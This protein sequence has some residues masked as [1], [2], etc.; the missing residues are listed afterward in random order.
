MSNSEAILAAKEA[1]FN[2]YGLLDMS[3]DTDEITEDKL[4]EIRSSVNSSKCKT[5]LLPEA[6][7]EKEYIQFLQKGT[8]SIWLDSEVTDI[9]AACRLISC[10]ANGYATNNPDNLT[11]AGRIVL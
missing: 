1:N 5:V 11:A 3:G 7:A 2:F 8:I 4:A 6:Y 10:G 9:T